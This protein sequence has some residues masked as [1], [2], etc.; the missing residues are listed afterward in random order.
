MMRE[1]YLGE[2]KEGKASAGFLDSGRGEMV[3]FVG[4]FER[5]EG[6]VRGWVG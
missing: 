1:R 3:G 6:R 2:G 5:I 4:V